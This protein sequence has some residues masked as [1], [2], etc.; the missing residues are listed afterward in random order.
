M[1]P[2]VEIYIDEI[3]LDGFEKISPELIR[4]ALSDELK[5]LFVDQPI[6]SHLSTQG[7]YSQVAGGQFTISNNASS[8]LIG[9]HV[10]SAVYTGIKYSRQQSLFKK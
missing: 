8:D 10:A 2:E 3:N 7:K 1:K 5:R 6:P 9:N 4:E